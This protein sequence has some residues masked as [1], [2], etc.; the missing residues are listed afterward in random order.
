MPH[1]PSV[2]FPDRI[3]KAGRYLTL[4]LAISF[5]GPLRAEP[6]D[7]A[8]DIK[9]L[10]AKNC[11]GCHGPTKQAASLRL[12]SFAGII[13]GGNLGTTLVP[14]KSAESLL[15]QAVSGAKK[16][17]PKMPLK[18]E[19][20]RDEIALLRRW[21]DEGAKGPAQEEVVAAAKSRHWSFQPIQ[22]RPLPKTKS[23]AWVR[24]PIDRF[25]LAELEKKG[26][27]PSP[28]ADRV[29][30]I[31]RLSLDLRGLPPTIE[32][33]E[34]FLKEA[35]AKPEEAYEALVDRLLASPHYGEVQARH[36][37]DQARYADSNGY[38]IDAPRS[39][40]K[41]RDWVIDAFNNDLPFDQFT[42]QQL[43][44][45]L[46][47]N[48]TIEQRIATGFHRNTQINQEGGI[49]LEQFRVESIVDR[50]GTTGTV[51]LGLTIGCCQCHDHK[52]DPISQREYYQFFAFFN[53]CDE[54]NLEIISPE[55]QKLRQEIR[56][57]LT[58][59]EK[60]LKMLDP[61][62][63]D[64]IE[65]WERSITE[66]T[67]PKVPKA[68]RDI[69]L[70]APA[71]RN[72]KQKKT[73][74]DAYRFADQTRHPIGALASPF[75][76]L[77]HT[78]F[79]QTRF[80]LVRAR[81]ELKKQEPAAITS[82]IIAER[83]A[84]ARQTHV[85]LGGDFLRKGVAVGPGT[86]STLHELSVA[87]KKGLSRLDLARWIVDPNNPMTA[88]VIVNRWWGQFFGNGIVETENDF[89]T[90]GTT[91]SHPELLDWLAAEFMKRKWSVKAMHKLIVMSAAYR[92]S[93]KARPDLNVVDPRNRLLARQARVRVAS[94]VVRDVC[95]ASSGLLNPKIGGPSVFP[96]Q[97][98]GVY[99]FT[100][101]DKAWKASTGPD[102]Y[103]R[104]MYTYFWR[105]AP[106][107]ALVVFDAPDASMTCT[108]R[109]RSNTPLQALTLLN[110]AGF[111]EY[112]GGMAQRIL[113]E[114]PSDDS[115]RL[116]YAF[117]LC[118]SRKPTARELS[119]LQGFLASQK[120]DF[121]FA[122]AEARRLVD[123]KPDEP[124]SMAVE[125]A[126]WMMTARVLM[127]LDE[128]IT[129]E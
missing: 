83:K 89:G 5:A 128:F 77:A 92:Q 65:L 40:W 119:R 41:Y 67:R 93:S 101:V 11:A 70:V 81:D 87:N 48:A 46:L 23:D 106:H 96:P 120:L 59:V 17:L 74:D 113:K 27:A 8:R 129:R 1:L 117:R 78:Q 60:H 76:A 64:N 37:L 75:S 32:E 34:V 22:T 116:N 49:D 7:Y 102:R 43:A 88:R 58:G 103:R 44:G 4:L 12:D 30:L 68:I 109:S 14:A 2:A 127:N 95:L 114:A 115:G 90:Q 99:R 121:A 6:V 100:Q 31:R 110:D 124:D 62:N 20:T 108:R 80:D 38:S 86:P 111:Y 53:N 105:S 29:T 98:E 72:A 45:D 126:S 71:G 118:M 122:V 123:A 91:P 36:W 3:M 24:N 13:K 47:P 104:G 69:F 57:R 39:I 35:N 82:M 84:A 66:E 51:W 50:V 26:I 18:G 112:A 125:R 19:L 79:L 63:A 54:P 61:T 85:L 9:P 42:I 33:V 16:D 97:P 15:I 28:E 25:I 73:L 56:D 107:P 94:E 52:F 55:A 21:I 10:L